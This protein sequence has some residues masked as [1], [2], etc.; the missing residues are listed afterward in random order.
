MV[1][2]AAGTFGEHYGQAEPPFVDA[3]Y[4]NCRAVLAFGEKRHSLGPAD[5]ADGAA[6]RPGLVRGAVQS[7]DG[8]VHVRPRQKRRGPLLAKY[9]R[10]PGDPRRR[11]ADLCAVLFRPRQA[12]HSLAAVADPEN[13]RPLF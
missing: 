4:V 10:M 5:R 13:S 3:I 1:A 9:L 11:G 12:G 7:A 6:F 2:L 8:R